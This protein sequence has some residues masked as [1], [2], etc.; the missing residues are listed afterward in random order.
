MLQFDAPYKGYFQEL[1]L[2]REGTAI[3][4]RNVPNWA[5]Q[6]SQSGRL[7]ENALAEVGRSLAEADLS[8]YSA[9]SMP[10]PAGLHTVLIF[11][12][13]RAYQRR[14][15]N[16]P[17]PTSIQAPIDVVQDVIKAAP[18]SFEEHRKSND[19]AREAGRI[20]RE[21]SGWN[22]PKELQL[23]PLKGVQGLLLT[24]N[25]VRGDAK[26]SVY[27]VLLFFPE[28]RLSY[29]PVD[30]A[31]WPNNP[32]A[33]VRLTFEHP[34]EPSGIG[35]KTVTHELVIVYRVIENTLNVDS[36]S[37]PL[38]NGNLFV[39]QL[40]KNWTPK[41]RAFHSYVAG[42]SLAP[43]ILD[44]FKAQLRTDRLI[45]SLTLGG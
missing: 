7:G 27:H 17:L 14:N 19:A 23:V 32:R 34:N 10:E 24:V 3:T 38:S 5:L 21:G 41:V 2:Y 1:R 25:G 31:N 9:S 44:E 39:I 37:F 28:G 15:L 35:I 42:P 29:Q 8:R 11:F 36:H 45:Q 22:V 18:N 33:E 30:P 16:G 20:L 12:D 40:D 13:G 26:T 43:V 6:N 4:F